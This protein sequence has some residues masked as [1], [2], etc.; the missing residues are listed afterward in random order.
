MLQ[1][2][3][4]GGGRFFSGHGVY[5]SVAPVSGQV[6]NNTGWYSNVWQHKLYWLVSEQWW[7]FETWCWIWSPEY[8]FVASFGDWL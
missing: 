6:N 3:L 5:T 4:W 2:F 8:Y 7:H 1:H